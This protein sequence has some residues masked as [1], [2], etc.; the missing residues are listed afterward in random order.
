MSKNVGI[1]QKNKGLKEFKRYY[2]YTVC[3][4]GQQSSMH[5][6]HLI[7]C[8]RMAQHITHSILTLLPESPL[9][10]KMKVATVMNHVGQE[11]SR[12]LFMALALRIYIQDVRNFWMR[13]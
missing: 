13:Q 8:V 7:M 5:M 6:R 4:H 3:M 1:E 11:V 2:E 9:K 12:G 10:A